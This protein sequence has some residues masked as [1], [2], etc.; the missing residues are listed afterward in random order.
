MLDRQINKGFQ[1][2]ETAVGK[3]HRCIEDIDRIENKQIQSA[4]TSK[5]SLM[6]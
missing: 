5:V 4:R 3:V 1:L 6:A 2:V